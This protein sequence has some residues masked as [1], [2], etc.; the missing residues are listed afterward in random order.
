VLKKINLNDYD[1]TIDIIN[2]AEISRQGRIPPPENMPE[3][4]REKLNKSILGIKELDRKVIQIPNS[5][6]DLN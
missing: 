5:W 4:L 3:Y 2:V 1:T 6:K